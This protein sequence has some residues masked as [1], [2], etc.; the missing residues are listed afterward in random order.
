MV[1]VCFEYEDQ[2]ERVRLFEELL[3]KV[4]SITTLL[5]TINAKMNDSIYDLQ[6]LA[7]YGRGYIMEKL[8]DLRFKIGP[9]SFFSNQYKAS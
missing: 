1:N 6:P 5:Y 8:G 4:P 3:K 7:Y 2:E 9:K